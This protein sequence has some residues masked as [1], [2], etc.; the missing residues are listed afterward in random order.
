MPVECLMPSC[1]VTVISGWIHELLHAIYTDDVMMI[2][3]AITVIHPHI[4]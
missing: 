1:F 2:D 3:A 4:G